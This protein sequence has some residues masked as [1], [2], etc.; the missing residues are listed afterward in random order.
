MANFVSGFITPGTAY[1]VMGKLYHQVSRAC[2][3]RNAIIEE[4]P[5][6][7]YGQAKTGVEEKP[8][9][10]E[11]RK[12]SF[13]GISKL[14]TGQFPHIDHPVCMHQGGDC[15]QYII[16]WE[17]TRSSVWK[18]ISRYAA[19]VS[20]LVLLVLIFAF[21]AKHAFVFS[22]VALL[23]IFGTLLRTLM[24]EKKELKDIMESSGEMAENLLDQINV[25][26]NNAVL[27]KEIGQYVSSILDTELLLKYLLS[28]LEKNLEFSRGMVMLANS[29]R[30]RLCIHSRLRIFSRT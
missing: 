23:L 28:T 25:R 19:L 3:S 6:G 17:S 14:L 15:C 26:Y 9:Q 27:I 30:T 10:C 5:G 4:Q 22:S 7:N 11:N 12:G 20:L 18:R 16:T 21:S 2:L 24:L 8:Y 29:D 13:E 1:S